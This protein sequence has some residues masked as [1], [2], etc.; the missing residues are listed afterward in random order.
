M[1]LR[2]LFAD[3]LQVY[4]RI[5]PT[6]RKRFHLRLQSQLN[7]ALIP[8]DSLPFLWEHW[9]V[10]LYQ[11]HVSMIIQV[12]LFYHSKAGIH[13][14]LVFEVLCLIWFSGSKETFCPILQRGW[15]PEHVCQEQRQCTP[16]M[17]TNAV[18]R[19]LGLLLFFFP[20]YAQTSGLRY[21]TEP[22]QEAKTC[23][24]R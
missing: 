15:R 24:S 2:Y 11:N 22:G 23:T 21:V 4:R 8:A 17:L 6:W 19:R 14:R 16:D 3:C 1:V 5:A 12:C 10:S 9:N 13:V 7:F 18:A 20:C